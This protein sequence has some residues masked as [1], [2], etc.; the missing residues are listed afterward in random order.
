MLHGIVDGEL[1]LGVFARASHI[2]TVIL[3]FI[4]TARGVAPRDVSSC[5]GRNVYHCSLQLGADGCQQCEGQGQLSDYA[6]FHVLGF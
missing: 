2:V 4:V 6:S 3:Y 5:F 1:Q